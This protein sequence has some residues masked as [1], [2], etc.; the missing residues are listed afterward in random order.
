[1][2]K[3]YLLSGMIAFGVIVGVNANETRRPETYSMLDVVV[4]DMNNINWTAVFAALDLMPGI[5]NINEY[6]SKWGETLLYMAAVQSANFIA[7]KTLLETYHANPNLGYRLGFKKKIEETP[8]L[9]LLSRMAQR[10]HHVTR[11]N[12]LTMVKLLLLYGADPY[13]KDA[14]GDAFWHVER[15]EDTGEASLA[16]QLLEIL[17]PYRKK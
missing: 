9:G 16:K 4:K 12:D 2:K 14:D 17:E 8:L 1:M 3:L 10:L 6:R 11:K 13:M 15:I 7:A 5:I